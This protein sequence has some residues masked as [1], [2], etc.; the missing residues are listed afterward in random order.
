LWGFFCSVEI[1]RREWWLNIGG[2]FSFSCVSEICLWFF[3]FALS[4]DRRLKNERHSAFAYFKYLLDFYFISEKARLL[5]INRSSYSS[6]R[7][8]ALFYCLGGQEFFIPK[9]C[10]TCVSKGQLA[11]TPLMNF[12]MTVGTSIHIVTFSLVGYKAVLCNRAGLFWE[13]MF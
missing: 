7:E 10:E 5:K 1:W 11:L 13:L 4:Q 12:F 2:S 8:N 9:G 3:F 6:R